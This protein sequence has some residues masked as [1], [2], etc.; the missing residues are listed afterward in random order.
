MSK[1]QKAKTKTFWTTRDSGGDTCY[2]VWD[3]NQFPQPIEYT[4]VKVRY[5]GIGSTISYGKEVM[6]YV[7]IGGVGDVVIG[8]DEVFNLP[9]YF[10][11]CSSAFKRLFGFEIKPGER[12]RVRF[13]VNVIGRKT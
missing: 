7:V 1:T 3:Y 5:K 2:D 13:S 8:K 12:K 9:K 4:D 11:L 6:R 10:R